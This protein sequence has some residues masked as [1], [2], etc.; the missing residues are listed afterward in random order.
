MN[1]YLKTL[2][3]R[4]FYD[5]I[6]TD[7]IIYCQDKQILRAHSFVL[8]HCSNLYQMEWAIIKNNIWDLSNHN[9]VYVKLVISQMYQL[10][11]KLKSGFYYL[12]HAI[13]KMI[14]F[15]DLVQ[16]IMP[17]DCFTKAINKIFIRDKQIIYKIIG[18]QKDARYVYDYNRQNQKILNVLIIIQNNSNEYLIDMR[19]KIYKKFKFQISKLIDI[20][21][22]YTKSIIFSDSDLF[23]N[24]GKEIVPTDLQ[25]ILFAKQI[26]PSIKNDNPGLSNEAYIKII[27]EK[28]IISVQNSISS[29]I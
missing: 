22:L 20:R 24:F 9:I 26:L 25:F 6:D 13:N 14:K 19:N 15:Y 17:T 2:Y 11:C 12:E 5:D 1:Q 7:V 4:G 10:N 23:I 18:E 29:T 27:T 8:R 3:K 28:W 21:E 16:Y